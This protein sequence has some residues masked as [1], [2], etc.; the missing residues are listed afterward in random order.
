MCAF[1]QSI[2]VVGGYD[3]VNQLPTVER[4]DVDTNQWEYV[5]RMNSPRSALGVAVVNN[6]IYA[7][8]ASLICIFMC[9]LAVYVLKTC[10]YIPP[11]A[12]LETTIMTSLLL[13]ASYCDV[14]V[15]AHSSRYI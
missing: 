12:K 15:T 9:D 3:S 7:V 13:R 1:D 4:Y 2:F 11:D 8:G 14:T 5:A 6:I 10:S